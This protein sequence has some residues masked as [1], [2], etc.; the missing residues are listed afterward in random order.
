M[1]AS[2]IG[3]VLAKLVETCIISCILFFQEAQEK[4]RDIKAYRF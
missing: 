3:D 2:G 4:S 1:N